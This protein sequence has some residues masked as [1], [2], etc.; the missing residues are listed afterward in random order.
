MPRGVDNFLRRRDG[1]SPADMATFFR[2]AKKIFEIN[3]RA[4]GESSNRPDIRLLEKRLRIEE[5]RL[6]HYTGIGCIFSD[7]FMEGLSCH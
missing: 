1:A 5:A 2:R 3:G 7:Q 6:F 4:G